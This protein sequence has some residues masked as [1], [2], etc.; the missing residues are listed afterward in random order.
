VTIRLE[1][2]ERGEAT[3]CGEPAG[4]QEVRS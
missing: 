4:L 3:A 1:A 2:L